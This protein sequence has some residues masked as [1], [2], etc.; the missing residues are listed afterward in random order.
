MVVLVF[1]NGSTSLRFS[2]VD[3]D[4]NVV[5]ANGGAEKIGTISSY[6]K[7]ENNRGYTKKEP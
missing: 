5:L 1:N 7:Y 4:N 2:I 6:F 3:T